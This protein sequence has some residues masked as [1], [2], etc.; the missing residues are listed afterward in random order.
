[1]IDTVSKKCSGCNLC[2]NICPK[3]AITIVNDKVLNHKPVV[4]MNKCINCKLCVNSCPFIVP[5]KKDNDFEAY[6]LAASSK[7]DENYI[8]A[9]SGGI[10]SSIIS[11]G[12]KNEYSIYSSKYVNGKLAVCKIKDKEDALKARGSKY[13]YS[14]PGEIYKEIKE[15]VK[16]NK[17]IFIGTPCQCYAVKTIVPKQF[18]SNL[19]TVGLVCHGTPTFEFFDLYLKSNG[20][21]AEDVSNISFRDGHSFH[22]KVTNFENKDLIDNLGRFDPYYL[23]FL[24]CSCFQNGCYSCPFAQKERYSDLT[25]GD[26]WG[27]KEEDKKK[28]APCKRVSIVI[29]SSEN[30]KQLFENISDLVDYCSADLEY[31]VGMNPQLHTHSVEDKNY[32][33]LKKY[34]ES[35]DKEASFDSAA[36]KTN[37]KRRVRKNKFKYFVKT[38]LLRLK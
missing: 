28:F 32:L 30:G 16:N 26:Y 9:S 19:F 6:A 18:A 38:K 12:L 35:C 10:A 2:S 22:I 25:I 21:K 31:A 8:G 37:I 34:F 17:V 3:S 24:D 15:E 1:M 7:D 14:N 5:P 4:D 20:V 13:V 11:Y 36:G 33:K 23:L 27:I 29:V